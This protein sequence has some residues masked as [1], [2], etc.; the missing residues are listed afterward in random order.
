MILP[1]SKRGG[2]VP[3]VFFA[4]LAVA[5]LATRPLR[6]AHPEMGTFFTATGT[7][8]LTGLALI[9]LGRRFRKRDGRV[10]WDPRRERYKRLPTGDTFAWIDVGLLGW[11]T[12]AFGAVISWSYWKD[13]PR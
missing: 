6:T 9:A 13:I 10:V 7:F 1:A 3:L 8:L 4:A 2:L 11:L 5:W 12:L